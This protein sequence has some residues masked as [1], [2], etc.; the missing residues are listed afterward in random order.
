LPLTFTNANR[1]HPTN[2]S[3]FFKKTE[4]TNV[5]DFI[6]LSAGVNNIFDEAVVLFNSDATN[7]HDSKFDA[8][9]LLTKELK[10]TQLYSADDNSILYAINTL[11][12]FDTNTEIP[13]GIRVGVKGEYTIKVVESNLTDKTAVYL[14][15]KSNNSYFELTNSSELKFFIEPG[16]HFNRFSLRFTDKPANLGQDEIY[17]YSSLNTFYVQSTM[18]DAIDGEITGYNISRK[19][20]ATKSIS[21]VY[22]CAI[23]VTAEQGVYLV[24]IKTKKNHFAKN[25]PNLLKKLILQNNLPN[26][27]IWQV[28]FKPIKSIL[29]SPKLL[30]ASHAPKWYMA[31]LL[32]I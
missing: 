10:V 11:P 14:Y 19:D 28:F 32:P 6:K 5:S 20:V 26:S 31:L 29:C 25:C 1:T 4:V 30:F 2:Q 16:N 3:L 21:N 17:I 23:D 13:L 27:Y 22:T 15:D 12:N 24:Q 9:R 18:K 8:Y 7:A